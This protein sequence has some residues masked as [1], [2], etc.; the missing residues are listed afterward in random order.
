MRNNHAFF[1]RTDVRAWLVAVALGCLSL[2]F[3][4]GAVTK[5]N[6]GRM[7][8][9]GNGRTT[10]L[11][12]GAPPVNSGGS[13]IPVSPTVGGWTQAGNYGVPPGASG[14]TM[15]LG[16]NGEAYFAGQKYPFQAGYQSPWGNVAGAALGAAVAIGCTFATGGLATVACLSLPVAMPFLY[17]WI[18]RSGGRINP[19]TG[20]LERTDRTVCTVGPCYHWTESHNPGVLYE[21]QEAACQGYAQWY[22]RTFPGSVSQWHIGSTQSSC[23]GFNKLANG[24]IDLEGNQNV[25]INKV[26]STYPPKSATWYPS[27]MDDIVPYM[28]QVNPDPRV[29]GEAI[30]KG[31]DMPLP[32][33]TVTG[34][35]SIQG[36]ET[37]KQNPDGTREVSRTTYNFT[38]NGNTITNT[39]NITTTTT[40]NSSN[41]QTGTTTSTS[42]PAATTPMEE[43]KD[44]CDKHPTA[45]GCRDIDFDTPA[46]DIPKDTK[47]VTFSA[48]TVGGSGSCPVDSYVS[49]TST[50]QTLKAWDWTATCNYFL[51]I[52]AIVMTLAAF[53]ALLIVMP[54]SGRPS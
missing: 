18:T 9:S 48:E 31:A 3:S 17:D 8:M 2:S 15:Q 53:S 50:G 49:L 7:G 5:G 22:M 1:H 29:W 40:Y 52:R 26:S 33:P 46:G 10:T 47:N 44:P 37:V 11:T 13:T 42:T 32:N 41:Q 25:G 12:P 19:S 51:P 21:G 28:Q 24:T 20:A 23:T 30:E 4:A 38:T 45:L 43:S 27:S 6:I 54:G 36:P 14:T 39:T 35:S 34:P 16:Q